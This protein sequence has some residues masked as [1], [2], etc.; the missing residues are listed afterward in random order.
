[1]EF[2]G[3]EKAEQG[4]EL[5]LFFLGGGSAEGGEVGGDGDFAVEFGPEAGH[6]LAVSGEASD[7]VSALEVVPLELPVN[8]LH[9]KLAADVLLLSLAQVFRHLSATAELFLQLTHAP[10]SQRKYSGQPEAVAVEF[11]WFVAVDAEHRHFLDLLDLLSG[12]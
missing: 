7:E 10:K 8:Q 2:F 4:L 11:C 1:M 6:V 9:Q 5:L 12:E 3:G